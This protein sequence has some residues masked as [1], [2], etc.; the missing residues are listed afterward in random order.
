MGLHVKEND[1]LAPIN[2]FVSPFIYYLIFEDVKEVN[3][4]FTKRYYECF[5]T[6]DEPI[7]DMRLILKICVV[8]KPLESYKKYDTN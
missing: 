1:I 7:Y 3:R 6:Y 5:Y 4:Y 8:D 2:L